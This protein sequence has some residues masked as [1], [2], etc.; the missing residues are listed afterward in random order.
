M[1]NIGNKYVCPLCG[2]QLCVWQEHIFERRQKIS[3]RTGE[4]S[5]RIYTVYTNSSDCYGVQCTNPN[6]GYI[7]YNSGYSDY[8]QFKKFEESILSE[9][10]YE[11]YKVDK[12]CNGLTIK[13]N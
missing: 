7:T 2:S 4:L 11:N 13:L 10:N 1:N 12:Y 8:P 6:C 9:V 3:P 5:Q